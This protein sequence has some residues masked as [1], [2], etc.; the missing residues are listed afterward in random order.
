MTLIRSGRSQFERVTDNENDYRS[1][2][3]QIIHLAAM[4]GY[5]AAGVQDDRPISISV[6]PE[7]RRQMSF[8][9]LLD[10]LIV[11]T[12]ILNVCIDR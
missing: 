11:S 5:D 10:R 9:I 2:V 8:T 6:S 7:S 3:S 4:A 12:D 1:I